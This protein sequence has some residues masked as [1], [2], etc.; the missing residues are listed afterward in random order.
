MDK[1]KAN[2]K[3]KE[4]EKENTKEK[5]KAKEK[6]KENEVHNNKEKKMENMQLEYPIHEAVFVKKT[7]ISYDDP[8]FYIVKFNGDPVIDEFLTQCVLTHDWE[9]ELLELVHLS[10]KELELKARHSK[11]SFGLEDLWCFRKEYMKACKLLE[12]KDDYNVKK[13]SIWELIFLIML[14]HD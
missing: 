10:K 13:L 5:E 4:K 12:N 1:E 11:Y 2:T 3:E 8:N 7:A 9:G 14:S 6:A